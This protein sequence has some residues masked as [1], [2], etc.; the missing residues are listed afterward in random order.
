MTDGEE[1]TAILILI[2]VL[3][4]IAHER[5]ESIKSLEV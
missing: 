5:A 1:F 3:K 4:A 2:L